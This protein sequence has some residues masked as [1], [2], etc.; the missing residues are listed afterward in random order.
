MKEIQYRFYPN[1]SPVTLK[2]IKL[3]DR[4]LYFF[5]RNGDETLTVP[6]V[7]EITVVQL[8]HIGDMI[9]ML[10]AI[11]ALKSIS[12]Y[13]INLLVSSSNYTIASK[14]NFIDNV[15]V[16]D[17]PYFSR[18]K[19]VSYLK[20]I[21][22]L[23]GIKAGLVY[24]VRGDLRNNFFI[25]F[26]VRKKLFAGYNVGGG[27]ALLD[28]VL[29]F[30]HGGH[31]TNLFKPLFKY[32]DFPAINISEYWKEEDM[33]FDEITDQVFPED[34]LVVHLGTGAQARKWPVDNF[35]RTI[36]LVS[37]VIPVYVMG[38]PDDL[39]PEQM[40]KIS[41]MPNTINCIG[42]YSMLQSIYI[43][44]KCSLF[45][46]LDS[47]FSH[48]ASLLKK[49]IVVLFSGTVNKDV[50]KPF[51]FYKDQVIL[52]NQK[53]ECDWVTGCGKLTCE[54]NICMKQITPA[55]VAEV[56]KENLDTYTTINEGDRFYR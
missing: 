47:G 13:K 5:K 52:L 16:A 42:K 23:M 24:D 56:I 51:S 15:L 49:K 21:R 32:L 1:T 37:G 30:A 10:P 39:S 2:R 9:L 55:K 4:F 29:P 22:Q 53:V 40:A 44:K 25:K 48:I 17:A 35:I 19:K 46:G 36:E 7:N 34:F 6:A 31:V 20:F 27:G 28:V 11:K 43:I 38:V 33:P 45:L 26:F 3:I 8:A 12:G 41:S 18:G 54:D 50:W 14:L